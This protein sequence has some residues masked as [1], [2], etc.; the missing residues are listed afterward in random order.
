[1]YFDTE[2]MLHKMLVNKEKNTIDYYCSTQLS[3]FAHVK[4]IARTKFSLKLIFMTKI[5]V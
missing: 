2:N 3:F 1:M 4:I 5:H